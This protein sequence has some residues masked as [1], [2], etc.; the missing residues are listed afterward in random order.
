MA[1]TNNG[2]RLLVPTRQVPSGATIPA[3]VVFD[4]LQY[5]RTLEMTVAKSDVDHI[6]NETTVLNIIT[7]ISALSTAIITEDFISSEDVVF[8]SDI[9]SLT[10]TYTPDGGDDLWLSNEEPNYVMNVVIYVKS[11]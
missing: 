2:T 9:V 7:E 10:S 6:S 8:W 3:V 5:K 4:D 11:N 1:I